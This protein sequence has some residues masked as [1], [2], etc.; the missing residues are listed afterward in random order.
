MIKSYR[1]MDDPKP[2]E[3]SMN[4][5]TVPGIDPNEQEKRNGLPCAASNREAMENNDHRIGSWNGLTLMRESG[6]SSRGAHRHDLHML[7]LQTHGTTITKW[8]SRA[9]SGTTV[10]RPG[11]LAVFAANA[12]HGSCNSRPRQPEEKSENI[13]ALVT[14][15]MLQA[16]GEAALLQAGSIRLQEKRVFR[17]PP[18]E[19]MVCALRDTGMHQSPVGPLVGEMLSSAIALHL[20]GHHASIPEVVAHKGGIPRPQLRRV[21]DYVESYLEE[22]V[23]LSS[24]AREAA[25]SIF[26]FSRAFRQSTGQSPYQYVLHRRIERA[27]VLLRAGELTVGEVGLRTG[28]VQ[29][30]HF[31]RLFRKKTGVTPSA[32]RHG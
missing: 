31:A 20:V 6:D 28:F 11:S 10:L 21:L 29:P 4:D 32:F 8:R 2:L 27:K 5:G 18:L 7:R 19:R 14:D 26:H 13:V 17:D 22:D 16:A 3:V 24:L 30:N 25:M 1:E 23:S 12:R 9:D 15:T